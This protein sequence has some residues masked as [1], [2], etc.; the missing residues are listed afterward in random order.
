VPHSVHVAK[1]TPP[2]APR[3]LQRRGGLALQAPR[4]SE[5]A[6]W[7]HYK[8]WLCE[9]VEVCHLHKPQ[10]WQLQRVLH[11]KIERQVSMFR[12]RPTSGKCMVPTQS[13]SLARL[14]MRGFIPCSACGPVQRLHTGIWRTSC[15]LWC[16]LAFGR[17]QAA[18]GHVPDIWNIVMLAMPVSKHKYLHV[19]PRP[20]LRLPH[21]HAPR[22]VRR[23]S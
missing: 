15:S 3:G 18:C 13:R 16:M 22:P 17:P 21:H 5:Q 10:R 19:G 1:G 23:T 14:R 4:G 11:R 9:R 12:R 8:L 7:L 20:P 6:A 2:S